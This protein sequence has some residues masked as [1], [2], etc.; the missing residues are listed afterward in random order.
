MAGEDIIM[1][2][3]KELKRFTFNKNGR[4]KT[5]FRHINKLW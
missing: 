5:L 2:R 1:L 4:I 3:Q